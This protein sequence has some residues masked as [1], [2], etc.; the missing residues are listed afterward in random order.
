M[1]QDLFDTIEWLTVPDVVERTGLAVSQVRQ[2]VKDRELL[3]VR[4][5]EDDTLQVPARFLDG[6][7]VLKAEPR[8]AEHYDAN[9]RVVE[10]IAA[11]GDELGATPAQVALAWLFAQGERFGLPVVPIPGSRKAS[12]MAENAGSLDLT[13]SDEQLQRLDAAADLVQ[14]DRQLTFTD[15][16]WISSNRE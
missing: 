10:V 7:G 8:F 1:A 16:Q 12:R 14:G 4:R 13:L 3:A 15:P 6:G 9:Q 2:L 5:G 11:V